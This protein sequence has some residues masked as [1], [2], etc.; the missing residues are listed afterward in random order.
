MRTNSA[1]PLRHRALLRIWIQGLVIF[2]SLLFLEKMNAQTCITWDSFASGFQKQAGGELSLT[3]VVG[4]PIVGIQRSDAVVVTTG[5]ATFEWS[6]NLISGVH[7]GAQFIP[8]TFS[9]AQN[10][11]NPFNP[12]TIIR[13][14]VPERSRVRLEIYNLLGQRI[15]TLVE[16]ERDAGSQQVVWNAEGATGLYFYRI[17]AV[18]VSHPNRRF[19]DVK[20][21]M[22]VK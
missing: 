18:S 17:E 2:L 20:K 4:Q 16:G 8:A 19:V 5:F 13:Y 6:G 3:S 9:L 12:S 21:M 11:P 7:E 15:R 10:Y 1:F 22:V 14:N